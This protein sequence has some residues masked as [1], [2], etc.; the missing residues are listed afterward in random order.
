MKRFIFL[1]SLLV[2]TIAIQAQDFTLRGTEATY[3]GKAT[4]LVAGATSLAKVCEI[5]KDFLYYYNIIVD[6]DTTAGGGS[7]AVSC[8]LAGS[9]DNTNY[10]TITDVT[11]GATADTIIQYTNIG[12]RFTETIG[13]V[14][15]ASHDEVHK[16]TTGIAAYT[17]TAS[18]SIL[19]D[20]TLNV[21][22]QTY[23]Y[24]DTVTVAAQT[25]SSAGNTIVEGGKMWK[26]LRVTL[27]GDG[28]SAAVELQAIRVKVVKIP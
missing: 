22:A 11:F 5:S 17:I 3:T 23:T 7:N 27:T 19:Y 13:A 25:L 6:I 14:T 16:G 18:D 26:Y 10:Y 9:D 8:I 21:A 28:A 24:T 1:I 12:T 20:D 4:D 15:I 2:A